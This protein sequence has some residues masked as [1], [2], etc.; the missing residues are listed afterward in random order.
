M[1]NAIGGKRLCGRQHINIKTKFLIN[2]EHLTGF[3]KISISRK[4]TWSN[5]NVCFEWPIYGSIVFILQYS[6][7]YFRWT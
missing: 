1:R 7:S 4:L 5:K 2:I 3:T 6:V